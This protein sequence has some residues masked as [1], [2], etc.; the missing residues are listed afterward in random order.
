MK[1]LLII[2]LTVSFVSGF[3]QEFRTGI[4]ITNKFSKKTEA[5]IKYQSRFYTRSPMSKYADVL[6]LSGKHEIFKN[7]GVTGAV[8]YSRYRTEQGLSDLMPDYP[9]RL[10]FYIGT[11]YQSKR[12]GGYRHSAKLQYLHSDYF[13]DKQ[14]NF[15]NLYLFLQ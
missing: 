14:K 13:S 2:I 5:G 12:M 8:R 6:Q 10:K 9:D 1:K 11:F 15:L 4:S 3:C 7:L